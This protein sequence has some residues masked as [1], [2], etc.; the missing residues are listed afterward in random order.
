MA[1]TWVGCTAITPILLDYE[2]CTP[3]NLLLTSYADFHPSFCDL[4]Q[5][6]YLPL[7]RYSTVLQ[8]QLHN[9]MSVCLANYICE[10]LWLY[11]HFA[12]ICASGT[13]PSMCEI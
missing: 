5:L 2:W 6:I 9:T 1:L 4:I 10:V 7:Q 12:H 8:P 3:Q 13:E 11:V